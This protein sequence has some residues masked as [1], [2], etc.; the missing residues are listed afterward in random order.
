MVSTCDFCV[1]VIRVCVRRWFC[2]LF[3]AFSLSVI[4]LCKDVELMIFMVYWNSEADEIYRICS[5]IGSPSHQSWSDG[6]KLAA[7]LNFQFPQVLFGSCSLMLHLCCVMFS[8]VTLSFI[9][10][11]GHMND[12][13]S[14]E[15]VYIGLVILSWLSC[16]DVACVKYDALLFLMLSVF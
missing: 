2:W 3:L 16:E 5:V 14:F 6:M 13:V 10:L 15:V 11:H 12:F 8:I 4:F 1:E 7:S 9:I